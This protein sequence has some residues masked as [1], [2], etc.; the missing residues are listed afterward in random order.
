MLRPCVFHAI[1][2]F[3]IRKDFFTTEVTKVGQRFGQRVFRHNS[4]NQEPKP[5]P[6]VFFVSLVVNKSGG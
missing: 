4:R 1:R 3:V 5:F 6:S 2:L